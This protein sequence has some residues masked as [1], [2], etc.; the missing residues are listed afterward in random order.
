M[1]HIIMIC[2]SLCYESKH[3]PRLIHNN[4]S[5]NN[6]NVVAISKDNRYGNNMTHLVVEVEQGGICH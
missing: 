3:L 4:N 6:C 5:L 2:G 1:K